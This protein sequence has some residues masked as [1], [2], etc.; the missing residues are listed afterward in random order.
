MYLD[1]LLTTSTETVPQAG[2]Y[3]VDMLPCFESSAAAIIA[4]STSAEISKHVMQDS[5]VYL[6]AEQPPFSPHTVS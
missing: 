1:G 5:Q 2:H 6:Q 4:C 3:V